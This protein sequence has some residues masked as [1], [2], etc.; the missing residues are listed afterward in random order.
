MVVT[1]RRMVFRVKS[2]ESM[3]DLLRLRKCLRA[4]ERLFGH[5]NWDIPIRVSHGFFESILL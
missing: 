2:Q 1:V 3:N 5:L 4:I